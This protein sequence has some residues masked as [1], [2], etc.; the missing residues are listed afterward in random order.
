M[1]SPVSYGGFFNSHS[2]SC[3]CVVML[4]SIY[5]LGEAHKL[6]VP[7]EGEACLYTHYGYHGMVAM[8]KLLGLFVN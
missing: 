5:A 4:S 7:E 8:T 1:F 2:Q 3:G 6:E